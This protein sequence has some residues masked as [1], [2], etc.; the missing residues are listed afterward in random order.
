M[1][2]SI[3]TYLGKP[4]IASGRWRNINIEGYR[5]QIGWRVSGHYNHVHV[6]VRK[7]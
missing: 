2:K 6:G 4:D 7:L 3:V 1:F 5:Y